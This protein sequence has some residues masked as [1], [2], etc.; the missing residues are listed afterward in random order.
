MI[1]R[2]GLPSLLGKLVVAVGLFGSIAGM[3][4]NSRPDR[5]ECAS[6]AT[7]YWRPAVNVMKGCEVGAPDTVARHAERARAHGFDPARAWER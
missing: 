5:S 4:A 7:L 2:N 3:V 6:A 1:G